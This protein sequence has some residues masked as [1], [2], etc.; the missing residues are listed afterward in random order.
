MRIAHII[1][2]HR[3]PQQLARL[4]TRL[5]YTQDSL[6]L[7][8]DARSPLAPFEQA[9][10]PLG[11]SHVPVPLPRTKCRWGGFGL[12]E[13]S[14]T[15]IRNALAVRPR[16]DYLCLLSGQDYPL[17]TRERMEARL[18]GSDGAAFL[19]HFSLP[20]EGFTDGGGL[21]RLERF[22]L[23]PSR[24]WSFPNRFV[25]LVPRRRLPA[26]L[27][28]YAGTQFWFLPADIAQDVLDAVNA[29]PQIIRF[30]RHSFVPDESFFQMLVLSGPH[31]D[32]VVN[33]DLR[34]VEHEA[35]ERHPRLLTVDSFDSLAAS[36]DLFAR[37]FD[38]GTD[39]AVL[40]RID[41]E[42][43]EG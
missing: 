28:P 13:A 20:R 23:R 43:L 11:R 16:P 40:D 26:G 39:T 4:I 36:A 32:R 35:G 34:Y 29:D 30:F 9:L 8:I 5:K 10:Q 33:D 37:K 31:R 22:Y 15:G 41:S 6:L 14:L 42:L 25:P 24:R 18:G 2:A 7:H 17:A 1:L 38:A 3:L 12:V 21:D 27:L 19:E